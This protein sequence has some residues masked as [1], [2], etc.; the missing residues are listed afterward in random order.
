MTTLDQSS[1]SINPSQASAGGGPVDISDSYRNSF[2]SSNNELETL[3]SAPMDVLGISEKECQVAVFEA[4]DETH[5]GAP[6]TGIDFLLSICSKIVTKN[7]NDN[8]DEKQA[9]WTSGVGSS[10]WNNELD[11]YNGKKTLYEKKY[12]IWTEEGVGNVYSYAYETR[13]A[14]ESDMNQWW[15]DRVMYET[16]QDGEEMIHPIPDMIKKGGLG[17]Y[18]CVNGYDSIT[19]KALTEY[20]KAYKNQLKERCHWHAKRRRVKLDKKVDVTK[21]VEYFEGKYPK[22]KK[23]EEAPHE[24]D[25]EEKEEVMNE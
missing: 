20:H 10:S 19:S 23:E 11:E 9:A 5:L 12:H 6:P 14:A 24:G 16:R 17:Q 22:E 15:S 7:N 21:A 4:L 2:L 25:D 1:T 18:G 13:E 3:I 8:D